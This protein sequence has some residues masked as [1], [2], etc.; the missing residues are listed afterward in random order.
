MIPQKRARQRDVPPVL[1][2]RERDGS[3]KI[4]K[5]EKELRILGGTMQDNMSWGAHLDWG[6][7][8]LLPAA[9]QKLGVLKHLG[10]TLPQKTRKMVAEGLILSKIR[11]LIPIWGGA[12]DTLIR[13]VQTLINDAARFVLNKQTR[14][15]STLVL[16]EECRWITAAEMVLYY[17]LLLL[18]KILRKQSPRPMT[19]K[20]TLDATGQVQTTRP[21]LVNTESAFRWRT[22]G[23]W[24]RLPEE[25]RQDTVLK[26]FKVSTKKLDNCTERPST[27]IQEKTDT[28]MD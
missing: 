18:W 1:I 21:R 7:E 15:D 20:F 22:I 28:N 10:R 25:I 24:N 14:R 16:M 27:L 12:G 8:A 2:E 6:E 3:E 5:S 19:E 9:R 23:T 11:Y 13:K 26:S 17:S 4:I